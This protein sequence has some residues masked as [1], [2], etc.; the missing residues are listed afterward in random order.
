MASPTVTTG[1]K[2]PSDSSSV[3]KLNITDLIDTISFNRIPLLAALGFGKKAGPSKGADSLSFPCVSTKHSWLNDELIPGSFVLNAAYTSGDNQLDLG[4]TKVLYVQVDDVLVIENTHYQVTSPIN[5]AGGIAP[6]RLL[7]SSDAAHAVTATVKNLGSAKLPGAT[8]PTQMQFTS[9]SQTDNYV[10]IFMDTVSVTDIEQKIA[11]YGSSDEFDRQM[12]KKFTEMVLKLERAAHD[13]IR[14]ASVNPSAQPASTFGGLR[15]FIRNGT[16]TIVEN[17]SSGQLTETLLRKQL[18]LIYQAGGTAD[19][20]LIPPLQYERLQD[21]VEP[22]RRADW[23]EETFGFIIGTY[24]SEYVE[25]GMVKVVIDNHLASSD[26]VIVDTK[27]LGI[28][29]FTDSAFT[30]EDL[31]RTGLSKQAMIQGVYTMEV[32]NATTNHAWI[33]TLATS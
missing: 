16:S 10:Q 31:P 9:L 15:Y 17:A 29:P 27:S 3:L 8:A 30:V 20:L 22:F 26:V 28:G 6:V 18:R 33:H 23:N 21:I 7:S 13:G 19:L 4:T 12:E 1:I 5:T 2:A 32:R 25:S 14:S 24:R 11:K